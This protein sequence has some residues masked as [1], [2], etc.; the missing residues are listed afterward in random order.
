MGSMKPVTEHQ[1]ATMLDLRRRLVKIAAPV[2]P[3]H[4]Y[5]DDISEID[6]RLN[7]GYVMLEDY[8]HDQFISMLEK[9]LVSEG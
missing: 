7:G 5:W 2:G 1:R 6:G 4:S 8:D 3:M 9:Q